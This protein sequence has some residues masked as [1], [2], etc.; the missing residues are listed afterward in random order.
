MRSDRNGQL[1]THEGYVAGWLDS[2]VRDFVCALP[3]VSNQ[4]KYALITCLDSNTDLASLV[5]RSPELKSVV[6]HWEVVGKGLLLPADLILQAG[7]CGKLFFGFDEAW[8]LPSKRIEP[9]PDAAALVGPGRIDHP[10][11]KKL[12]RWM[13]ANSCSLALGDGVGLNFIVKARGLL[14]YLL[15]HSLCQP[16]P[17]IARVEIE[18]AS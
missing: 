11:L 7:L 4:L 10:K 17:S 15:A 6:R 1:V 16:E 5:N 2:S 12:S 18:Q 9:I 13:S 8:F 3:R 14:A